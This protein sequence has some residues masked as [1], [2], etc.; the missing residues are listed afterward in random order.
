MLAS[1]RPICVRDRMFAWRFSGRRDRNGNSPQVARLTVQST[2]PP[3]GHTLI[4]PLES[5]LWISEEAH[6]LRVGGA[7]HRASCTPD[8]VRRVIEAALDAGWNPSNKTP[9]TLPTDLRLT[10]YKTRP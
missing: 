5:H 6:D 7:I 2:N 1:A 10:C 9:F 3:V 8:D 4:V